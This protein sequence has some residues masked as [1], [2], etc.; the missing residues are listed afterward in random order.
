MRLQQG[1][2]DRIRKDTH[3]GRKAY[4]NPGTGKRAL[5]G[6]RLGIGGGIYVE[7]IERTSALG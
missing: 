3:P 7:A 6:T 5:W 4:L 1:Q 2:G